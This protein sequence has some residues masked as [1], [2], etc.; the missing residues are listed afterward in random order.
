MYQNRECLKNR[1]IERVKEIYSDLESLNLNTI[2]RSSNKKV[3]PNTDVYL[4]DTY[5]ETKKFFNISKIAFIG[6][7]IISHD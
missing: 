2:I 4:V 5:G 7:S 1:Y 6:G 3:N